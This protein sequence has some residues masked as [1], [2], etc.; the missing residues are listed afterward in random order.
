MMFLKDWSTLIEG[1]K[2]DQSEI[3][4]GEI[5]RS[6]F[7][8]LDGRDTLCVLLLLQIYQDVFD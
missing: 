8:S 4:V 1:S 6:S 7:D 3:P 5:V 2:Q